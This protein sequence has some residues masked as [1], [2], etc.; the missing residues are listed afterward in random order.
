MAAVKSFVGKL[1]HLF[2]VLAD[3]LFSDENY[4]QNK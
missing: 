4:V 3:T 2:L 1:E